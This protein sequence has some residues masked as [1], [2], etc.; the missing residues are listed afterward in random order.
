[1]STGIERKLTTI[2]A[3]DVEGY[4]R[5]ME[6]DEV[7]AM[8][9]LQDCRAVFA[10][11]IERHRGRIAN[12]AGDGLIADFPS[13]VEA[14]QC[15]VEVQREFAARNRQRD[16]ARAMR[17]R[18]GLHL[19]DV[20]VDQGDLFGEGVNMAARLQSMAEPGGVL[21]SQAVYDQVHAK[22][23]VGYEP[24][25]ERRPKNLAREVSVYRLVLDGPPPTGEG[26]G[27]TLAPAAADAGL[28][29]RVIGHAQRLGILWAALAAVNLF[30]SDD[31]WAIWPGIVIVVFL[32]LEAAPLLARGWLD[33]PLAR[34][35]VIV[36]GL[37]LVNLASRSGEPW[38]LWPAGALVVAYLLRR[39][40]RRA[41]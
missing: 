40:W 9:A 15:A 7:A 24:L 12:T 2:L 38:F 26:S 29:G 1:V 22:L 34:L 36:A 13:V 19:G 14:V 4:S 16:Q 39:A 11:F 30:T 33:A 28:R 20:M 25:G 41:G 6:A 5:L 3:A 21:I 8:A 32:G 23:A 35:A 37:A 31:F 18:I 10:R 27:R 17:F